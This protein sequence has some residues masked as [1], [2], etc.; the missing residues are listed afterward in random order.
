[1][2]MAAWRCRGVTAIMP[3]AFNKVCR[4]GFARRIASVVIAAELSVLLLGKLATR[5]C[6]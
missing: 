5:S 4:H 2:I 6:E 3:W 1:M